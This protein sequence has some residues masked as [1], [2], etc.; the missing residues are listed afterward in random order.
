MPCIQLFYLSCLNCDTHQ[1]YSK[2]NE[3]GMQCAA[4]H[5]SLPV[6]NVAS[7]GS[8]C[9]LN[10]HQ[11]SQRTHTTGSQPVNLV[12]RLSIQFPFKGQHSAGKSTAEA[13]HDGVWIF[14]T[15]IDIGWRDLR[16]RATAAGAPVSRRTPPRA[17]VSVKGQVHL[18]RTVATNR[19]RP[20]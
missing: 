14:F 17:P 13:R 20:K 7:L 9:T 1:K 10:C 19:Y 12:L 3:T 18:P 16:A 2:T 6:P 4:Q 15:A 5:L 8:E 11:M